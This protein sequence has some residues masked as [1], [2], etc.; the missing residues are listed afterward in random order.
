MVGVGH[1]PLKPEKKQAMIEELDAVAARLYGLDPDQ[2]THIFD[3]FH[4]WSEETKEKAWAA[5]R[6]R[7]LNILRSLP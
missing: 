1:G 5:R 6:D 7:T 3:T 2:L 4:E